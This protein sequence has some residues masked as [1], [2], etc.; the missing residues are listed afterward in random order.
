MLVI[1]RPFN[2]LKIV[3]KHNTVLVNFWLSRL[4]I[5]PGLTKSAVHQLPQAQA[6]DHQNPCSLWA[7]RVSQVTMQGNLQFTDQVT[8]NRPSFHNNQLS[9][10]NN[11]Q[12]TMVTDLNKNSLKGLWKNWK[13]IILVAMD[14]HRMNFWGWKKFLD[15]FSI[16]PNSFFWITAFSGMT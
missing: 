12:S 7:R 16:T 6:V 11:R 13:W 3:S 15:N 1:F 5:W 9:I 14:N 8:Y 2:I 10:G 4:L